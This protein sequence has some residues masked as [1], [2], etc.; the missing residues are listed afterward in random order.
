VTKIGSTHVLNCPRKMER[1]IHILHTTTHIHIYIT[2]THAPIT[3]IY[4]LTHTLIHTLHS[5]TH[6]THTH[7]HTHTHIHFKEWAH[8]TE[9]GKTSELTLSLSL[10]D[11][12]IPSRTVVASGY[13]PAPTTPYLTSFQRMDFYNFLL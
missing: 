8:M 1:K 10:Q 7:T 5:H 4:T 2:Y 9:C 11:G 12:I 6:Y 3:Y 13:I